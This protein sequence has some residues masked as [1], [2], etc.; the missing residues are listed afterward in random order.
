MPKL[1]PTAQKNFFEDLI[2]NDNSLFENLVNDFSTP[3]AYEDYRKTPAGQRDEAAVRY[4]VALRLYNEAEQE[5]IND[6]ILNDLYKQDLDTTD[7]PSNSSDTASR[8][9]Y[10]IP[11]SK[12]E[13]LNGGA[14][15]L[16]AALQ[17]LISLTDSAKSLLKKVNESE[18][19]IQKNIDFLDNHTQEKR[20]AVS[21]MLQT[22]QLSKITTEDYKLAKMSLEQ[23]LQ[24]LDQKMFK[25]AE[26]EAEAY[27]CELKCVELKESIHALK[28]EMK[29]LP[30]ESPARQRMVQQIAAGEKVYASLQE[31]ITK[32]RTLAAG[33]RQNVNTTKQKIHSE[34]MTRLDMKA[35]QSGAGLKTPAEQEKFK[36]QEARRVNLMS[37]I[38]ARYKE[39]TQPQ[40]NMRPKPM[41]PEVQP[42][43]RTGM[44]G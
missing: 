27:H 25:A 15:K 37:S 26:R 36:A 35:A 34:D 11:S 7:Q 22:N 44:A 41:E 38:R 42:A 19:D 12:D 40:N 32:L 8:I 17:N 6:K 10:S 4:M 5:K 16:E 2:K 23:S 24:N 29:L 43:R 21:T 30:P 20:H 14:H 3:G 28:S 9:S 39:D 18:Q 13:L 33:D 31:K 1:T